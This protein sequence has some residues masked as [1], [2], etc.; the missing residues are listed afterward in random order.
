MLVIKVLRARLR[1]LLSKAF[2]QP[3]KLP[4]AQQLRWLD[5]WQ[6]IFT[7]QDA[8]DGPR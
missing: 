2:K 4:T 8:K 3:G 6:K 5:I 1:E 7:L